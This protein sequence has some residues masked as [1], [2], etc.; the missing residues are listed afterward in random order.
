MTAV[1]EAPDGGLVLPRPRTGETAQVQETWQRN[2]A[3]TLVLSDLC[4]AL[5]GALLAV[6]AAHL[7]GTAPLTDH[8]SRLVLG[9][10]GPGW[11]LAIAASG[12]YEIRVLGVGSDEFKRVINAAVR[13]G[14][15]LA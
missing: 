6:A 10:A 7:L 13:F 5:L 15:S 3:A 11:L 1:T 9:F 4:C 12:G 14:A 2:Y 8:R